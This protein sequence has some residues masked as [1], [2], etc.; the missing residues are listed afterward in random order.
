MIPMSLG[1]C[2]ASGIRLAILLASAG[3]CLQAQNIGCAPP[4]SPEQQRTLLDYVR[5]RYKL[6]DSIAL[7]LGKQSPVKDTCYRELTFRGT[8]QVRTWDL[9]LYLT[10]DLRFLSSDILD[11][12]VD[13]AAE[14]R[15][16][17]AALLNG[18]AQ[19]AP[20]VRGSDK[21]RVTIAVFSDFQCPF[22]RRFAQYLDEVLADGAEDVRVV[23]HHMPL[24]GHPWARAAAV[25]A[26]CA[27]LQSSA[28]F[29]ALH[30]QIFRNQ[31][32]ITPANLKDKLGEFAKDVKGLDAKAFQQC[33]DG[34]M[35]LGLVLQDINLAAAAHVDGTPTLFVNGNRAQGVGTAAELREL[36][37]RA[38]KE[39][40]GRGL[41]TEP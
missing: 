18:L 25:G 41:S 30:D 36:I 7:E 39:A 5:K 3:F 33:V 37:S 27:Q 19:G 28:A 10:P 12:S 24:S 22:C 11:T 16:K 9:T 1:A 29:W 20:A 40:T 21:S 2:Y 31:E 35:S 34:G 17:D 4:L 8:S 26:G 32:S 23:F 38:R 6:P 14:Q 15:A 13:P